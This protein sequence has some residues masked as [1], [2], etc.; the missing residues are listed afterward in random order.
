MFLELTV[1]LDST[2]ITVSKRLRTS[3]I[4][5]ITVVVG[6]GDRYYRHHTS[7]TA[8]ID[9]ILIKASMAIM[10]I[11]YHGRGITDLVSI[12][13]IVDLV[14]KASIDIRHHDFQSTIKVI[15]PSWSL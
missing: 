6:Y 8:L 10:D 3:T 5:V 14:I 13:A 7:I 2:D 15:M 1:M 4:E 12:K 9:I 11:S